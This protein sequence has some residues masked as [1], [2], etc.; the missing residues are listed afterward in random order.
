VSDLPDFLSH[1]RQVTGSRGYSFEFWST[2]IGALN[3]DGE[4]LRANSPARNAGALEAPVLLLHGRDD[5]IVPMNQSRKMRS[6]LESA[7]KPVDLIELDGADHWLST[8]DMR[9]ATLRPVAEFV[10]THLGPGQ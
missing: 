10:E 2:S 6:A 3:E 4:A 5:T 9:L 8:T 1:V 7:G